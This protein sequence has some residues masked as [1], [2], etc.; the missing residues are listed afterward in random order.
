MCARTMQGHSNNNALAI[1]ASSV[2]ATEANSDGYFLD[3][4]PMRFPLLLDYLRDSRLSVP[5]SCAA[6]CCPLNE[7]GYYGLKDARKIVPAVSYG[8]IMTVTTFYPNND[9]ISVQFAHR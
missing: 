7:A 3:R 8:H 6:R 9:D 2:F 1:M 5:S 4:G